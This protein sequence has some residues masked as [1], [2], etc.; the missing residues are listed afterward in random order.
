MKHILLAIALLSNSTPKS[1][2]PIID[3]GVHSFPTDCHYKVQLPKTWT[4]VNETDTQIIL[5]TEEPAQI[6]WKKDGKIHTIF[7]HKDNAPV[8]IPVTCRDDVV[9]REDTNFK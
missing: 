4:F 1:S 2:E 9:F 5:D 6:Y 3:Y 8:K 7:V